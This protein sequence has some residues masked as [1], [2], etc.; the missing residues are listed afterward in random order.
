[1]LKRQNFSRL[2]QAV[3]VYTTFKKNVIERLKA[4]LKEQLYYLIK[5][6]VNIT[7]GN[8]LVYNGENHA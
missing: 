2:V 7:K 3:E 4:D 6:S 1:M 5:T 8:F